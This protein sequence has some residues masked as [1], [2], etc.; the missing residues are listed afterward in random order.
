MR[1]F[2]YKKSIQS[3]NFFAVKGGGTINKMKA[4]KL[5]WLADRL[6]LRKY[7]RLITGDIY[8]ALPFGPVPS[9]T[10]DFLEDSPFLTEIEVSYCN[11]FL[12]KQDKFNYGSLKDPEIK[13]FSQTDTDALEIVFL[14][15]NDL[16]HFQLSELS[17]EFPEWKKYQ[18]ALEKRLSSRFEIDF[19]DFFVNVDDGRGVFVDDK[20]SLDLSKHIYFDNIKRLSIF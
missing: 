14:K 4:I 9:T 2:N 20:L 3:L 15:Y 5:I 6:H 1:G 19:E 10:R 17:H 8:F 18:S 7:G 11:E 13:V 16:D 12:T